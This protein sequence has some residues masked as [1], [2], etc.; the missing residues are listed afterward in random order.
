MREAAVIVQQSAGLKPTRLKYSYTSKMGDGRIGAE[1]DLKP[2]VEREP[3]T[4]CGSLSSADN[5]CRLEEEKWLPGMMESECTGKSGE[6][7]SDDD[8]HTR[9]QA[10]RLIALMIA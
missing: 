2:M 9:G 6:S 3:L 10:A 8:C 4:V 1:D 5:R 7:R